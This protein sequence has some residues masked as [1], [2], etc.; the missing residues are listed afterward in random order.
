MKC[1]LITGGERP[2]FYMVREL[3]K[4][5]YTCIA[6]SGFDWAYENSLEFNIIV[7]D[8]DSV[9]KLKEFNS[10]DKKRFLSYLWIRMIQILYLH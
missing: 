9:K 3:I 4:A 10:I 7:G 5:D 6:D 8:M 1:V 2:P